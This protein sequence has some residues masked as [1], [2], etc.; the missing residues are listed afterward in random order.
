MGD[1]IA[2][3][4]DGEPFRVYSFAGV[5]KPPGMFT[6]YIPERTWYTRNPRHNF[7]LW[8]PVEEE[9]VPHQFKAYILLFL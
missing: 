3:P 8:V 1:Y 4:T 7:D 2:F 6:Y 5:P 9:K